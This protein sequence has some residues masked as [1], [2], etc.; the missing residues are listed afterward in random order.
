[1]SRAETTSRLPSSVNP[2]AEANVVRRGG[3]I[4]LSTGEQGEIHLD[5]GASV[6]SNVEAEAIGRGGDIDVA[7]GTLSVADGASFQ[8]STSG[9]G[10]AGNV[11]IRAQDSVTFDSSNAFSRVNNDAVGEGGSIE[12]T[13]RTLS[14]ANGAQLIADTQGT[15]DAGDVVIHVQDSFVLA[16]SNPDSGFASAVFSN[17]QENAVGDGGNIEI[18]A[19]TLSVANGAQL[20]ADTQGTGD[21]G[22]VVIH[23]QDS[24][25]LAGSNPDSGFASAVFSDVEEGAVG[26]G[27]NISITANLL[28]VADGASFQAS[29]SGRGDAGNVIIRAQDSVTFDSSNAFSNVQENAVGDGGNIEITASTLSVDN[30]AQLITSSAGDGDAGDILLTNSSNVTIAGSSDSTGRAS[31]L[32]TDTSS[33]GTGGDIVITTPHFRLTNGAVIDAQTSGTGRGGDITLN[34]SMAEILQGGQMARSLVEL[35]LLGVLY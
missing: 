12:I 15:G 8:A 4:S 14:V 7:T 6:L 5:N 28:S 23:V 27:G 34:V 16:G 21:A 25:V 13:A 24:F 2:I 18:T 9:R 11:I 31:S 17:V 3:R 33:D 26:D 1:M 20:I 30:G 32:F 10:D 35:V 19:R 22:D 29:T